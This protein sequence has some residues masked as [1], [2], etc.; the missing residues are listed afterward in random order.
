MKRSLPALL[1]LPLL[2]LPAAQAVAETI[3]YYQDPIYQKISPQDGHPMNDLIK[4]AEGGDV[5]AQFILGD[6]YAKGKGG[7]SPSKVK[8]RDWFETSARSGFFASFIRLAALAKREEK[9]VEAYQWYTLCLESYGHGKEQTHCTAA[10]DAV[11]ADFSMSKE[12][13]AAAKKAAQSWKKQAQDIRKEERRKEAAA[14]EAK[15]LKSPPPKTDKKAGQE[16]KA[17]PKNAKAQKP[18]KQDSKTQPVKKETTY[19]E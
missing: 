8:A 19:N 13:I 7:L 18:E 3:K 10:R 15:M 1:L 12:Q 16:K 17:S 2:F 14:K 9:P 6:L 4:L 11:M 5:R